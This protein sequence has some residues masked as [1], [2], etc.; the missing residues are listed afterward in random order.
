MKKQL[1][2][3]TLMALL[4]ALAGCAP[5]APTAVSTAAK[6][7]EFPQIISTPPT[8]A[9]TPSPTA[10]PDPAF[11]LTGIER[12]AEGAT[13][14]VYYEIFVRAFADGNGDGKG[15]FQGLTAKL[16]Y[17]NDGRDQTTSDLGVTGLWLM[18]VFKT[19]SYHGYDVIDY[20]TVNPDYGTAEDFSAFLKAAHARGIRVILDLVLNHTSNLNRWFLSS[21]TPG[22]P[23]RAWYYWAKDVDTTQKI[24]GHALWNNMGGEYYTGI[25]DKSMPDLNYDTPE[26]RA[27]MKKVAKY[28][29]DAGVDGFRLDAA[30]HLYNGVK[31]GGAADGEAKCLAWWAE[32]SSYCRSVKPDC[33]L[34]G[35]VWDT[36]LTRA[37]YMAPLGSDFDF[38]LGEAL[39]T[40]LKNGHSP[41]NYLTKLMAG[42][43]AKFAKE[44]PDYVDAPFLSNHDQNRI[45]SMLSG[46]MDRMR[47]AASVYLTL[48]GLPFMYY[49]EEIGMMGAKP[50]EQIRTPMLWGGDDPLQSDWV[51]SRYNK[52]TVPVSAQDGDTASLLNL[53]RRLIRLR[54]ANEALYAGRLTPLDTGNDAVLGWT[55]KSA[56]QQAVVLH[57]LGAESVP[58]NANIAGYTLAFATT[59]DGFKTDGDSVTL[60]ATSSAVFVKQVSG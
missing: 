58:V 19:G 59:Q 23:F 48:E 56:G 1:I 34:V 37:K 11:T 20:Y 52:N 4:A 55:M 15:D 41:G 14:G 44:N 28:W 57:N 50:D 22:S 36:D 53:Y 51:D 31:T 33:Y 30:M 42:Q 12:K 60:P 25:F 45:M 21:V 38:A 8:L 7:T 3:L 49:G 26:V 10:A 9:P 35:E 39:V 54:T 27:E 47:L 5:P 43:Y 24:W 16:D 17:L 40:A 2:A 18:P 29:L 6:T 13:E 46:K 32:F